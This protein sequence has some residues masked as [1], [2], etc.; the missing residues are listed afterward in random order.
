MRIFVINKSTFDYD[1]E[2]CDTVK[3]FTD[4]EKAESYADGMNKTSAH[5]EY[6]KVESVDL[7]D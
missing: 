2:Y 5:N 4:F 6:F 7:V 1:D 3:A